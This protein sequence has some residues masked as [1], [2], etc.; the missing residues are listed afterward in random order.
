MYFINKFINNII[1]HI[2]LVERSSYITFEGFW[3]F[4]DTLLIKM[5][6]KTPTSKAVLIKLTIYDI[7]KRL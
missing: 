2:N 4:G 6:K 1:Q 7:I 3:G 5:K